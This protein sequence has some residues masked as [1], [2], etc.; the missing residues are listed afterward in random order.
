MGCLLFDSEEMFQRFLEDILKSSTKA[1]NILFF[2]HAGLSE[3][4]SLKQVRFIDLPNQ[5]V[6]K[7]TCISKFIFLDQGDLGFSFL[8]HHVL[9]TPYP[10]IL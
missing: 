9:L 8:G 3:N 5:A 6:L 1:Y 10:I 7:S 2:F 4:A